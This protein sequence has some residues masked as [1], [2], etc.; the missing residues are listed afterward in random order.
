MIDLIK[1]AYQTRLGNPTAKNVLVLLTHEVN[2]RGYGWPSV[3]YIANYTEVSTRTVLRIIQVFAAIGLLAKVKSPHDGFAVQIDLHK[4]GQNLTGDFQ[5]AYAVAQ[6][7]PVEVDSGECRSDSGV[8]ATVESVAETQNDVAE[9]QNSVAET[10]PPHPH[11]GGPVTD[12]LLTQPPSAGARP[13]LVPV[14]PDAGEEIMAAV[15]L[16]E[17]LAVPSDFGMRSLA[18]QAIRMQA[19]E[20][21]GVEAAAER[22][23]KAAK[24]AKANGETRWRF[25]LTDQ[26]YLDR[27]EG[28]PNQQGQRREDTNGAHRP[29]VT[30]QR[31]DGNLAALATALKRRGIGGTGSADRADGTAVSE[32]GSERFDGRI[33]GG[34]RA[35]VPELLAPERARGAG[36]VAH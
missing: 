23:L 10:V 29:S 26:G 1:P 6:G 18:A 7:K 28:K 32:S 13:M 5:R 9:T 30:K 33:P 31:I 17:E 14:N 27:N 20:W 3:E 11:K 35:V 25:W 15:W 4:L 22:I 16:F 12:P 36:G 21:G 34:F 24:D 8:V 2:S 19:R